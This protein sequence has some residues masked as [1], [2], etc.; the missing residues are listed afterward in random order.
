[1]KGLYGRLRSENLIRNFFIILIIF[2]VS[3]SVIVS[4]NYL[5]SQQPSENQTEFKQT[6]WSKIDPLNFLN[7]LK[8]HPEKPYTIV[9]YP[10]QDWIKE[11]H[12]SKLILMINSKEPASPVVAVISSYYPFNQTSTVGNEAMFLIE[13]FK[14]GRYPPSLCS[15][16][17]FKGNPEEY[18]KWWE[19][20]KT[21]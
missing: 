2:L 8:K 5:L 11:K 16:Y 17:Y 6:N 4:I 19:E 12:V 15:L 18:R 13:G 1:M 7:L 14:I 3:I 10:P 21:K 9:N 20:R